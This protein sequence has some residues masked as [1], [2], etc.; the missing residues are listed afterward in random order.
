MPLNIFKGISRAMA[1]LV[2]K[3]IGKEEFLNQLREIWTPVVKAN[4]DTDLEVANAME[5][6]RKSGFEKSFKAVGITEDDIRT[7][8]VDIQSGKGTPV[9][10][11]E[12][13]VGR[14]DPCPCGS[15]KKYKRCCGK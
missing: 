4:T 14:N 8:L 9:K 6:V 15:R 2:A 11:N 1:P 12:P 5:R 3:R 7:L 10:R 13:K